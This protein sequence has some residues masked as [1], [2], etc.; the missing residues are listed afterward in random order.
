ME[1]IDFVSGFGCG[2]K[3]IDEGELEVYR[4]LFGVNKPVLSVKSA[5]GDARAASAA[6]ALAQAA[7]VLAGEE[8]VGQW[9]KVAD[10]GAEPSEAVKGSYA[11]A[12]SMGAGGSYS[13]VVIK[14]A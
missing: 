11:L 6:M 1:Q 14:K 2:I 9:Y 7:R 12:V 13:A 8:A 3:D 5:T 4:E 10:K